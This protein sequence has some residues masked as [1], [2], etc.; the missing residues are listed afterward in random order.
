MLALDT[1]IAPAVLWE[2]D[3]KDLATMVDILN[4]RA[5]HVRGGRRGR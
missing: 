5:K 2:A 4:D 1:G 3:P